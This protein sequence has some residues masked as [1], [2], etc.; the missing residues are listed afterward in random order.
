MLRPH[1]A[2]AALLYAF[3][4]V[5]CL[6]GQ[7]W[8]QEVVVV[9]VRSYGQGLTEAAAVKDAIVQAVGQVTGERI[10]ASTAVS[11]RDAESSRGSEHSAS[12]ESTIDSIIRGVVRSSQTISVDRD[13]VTALYRAAVDVR[14]ASFRKSAQL[15]RVRLAVVA[16]NQPL[17]QSLTGYEQE[18]V[19]ALLNGL[20]D[21]LVASRKFAVLDRREQAAVQAEYSH[22]RA[23]K[24]G[25]EDFVRLQSAAAADFLVI[26]NVQSFSVGQSAIGSI[27]AKAS[28]RAVV[29]DYTSGQVRQAVTGTAVK[30]IKSDSL[31]PIARQIGANLAQQIIDNAFPAKVIGIE[32][33][34]M[35]VSAGASQFQ[36][37]DSVQIYQHGR[38]LKD[39]DT[40][41]SLGF[42]EIPVAKATVAHV[43][44]YI[45]VVRA[46]G[47]T[48]FNVTDIHKQTFIV[49]RDVTLEVSHQ[50]QLEQL[51]KGAITND[52][53]W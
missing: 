13:A 37:G 45:T 1:R 10:S 18:F 29:L 11:T 50:Q 53:D 47:A 41:E 4:S 12:I 36:V 46:G 38:A 9:P 21:Q 6:V 26:A 39:P 17:P 16:G 23:G 3:L 2:K 25:V 35:T 28:A 34:A 43:T 19:Q 5:F 40:G 15:N 24:T 22:I 33:N 32:G 31:S 27:R 14:V 44:P 7:V 42:S 20:S 51:K 52:S 8:S 30:N 49:R 48:S